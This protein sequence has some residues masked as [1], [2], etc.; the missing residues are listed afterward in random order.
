MRQIGPAELRAWQRARSLTTTQMCELL[1]ISKC[2]YSRWLNARYHT[3]R[4]LSGW[5]DRLADSTDL[6]KTST[7]ATGK[8]R[9]LNEFVVAYRNAAGVAMSSNE[10]KALAPGTPYFKSEPDGTW[11]EWH[12]GGPGFSDTHTGVTTS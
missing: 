8:T 6:P 11:S 1:Q 9:P 4:W 7:A 3:P 12:R 2:T 5:L 10:R